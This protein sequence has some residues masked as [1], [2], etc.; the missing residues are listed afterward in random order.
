MV[1]GAWTW[2]GSGHKKPPQGLLAA[3]ERIEIG[4]VV[5]EQPAPRGPHEAGIPQDSQ[6]L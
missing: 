5:D 3:V 4:L 2:G 6:V 1:L